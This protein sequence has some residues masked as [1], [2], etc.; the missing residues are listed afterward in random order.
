A[1]PDPL[2]GAVAGRGRARLHELDQQRRQ[3][4]AQR[5]SDG[6]VGRRHHQLAQAE[7]GTSGRRRLRA[8][9]PD[10]SAIRAASPTSRSRP[11]SPSSVVR[12]RAIATPSGL[13]STPMARRP[14][15]IASTNTVPLPQNGSTTVSPDALNAAMPPRAIDG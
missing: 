9:T 4:E 2:L 15:P 7:R 5:A 12:A 8:R 10:S 11:A 6:V 13:A 3:A 1:A 14:R